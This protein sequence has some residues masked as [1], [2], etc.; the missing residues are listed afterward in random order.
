[1]PNSLSPPHSSTPATPLL[2]AALALLSR[3]C[4]R[5]EMNAARLLQRAALSLG[6]SQAEREICLSLAEELECKC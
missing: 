3:R 1:M 4:I 2:V 6:L 5:N